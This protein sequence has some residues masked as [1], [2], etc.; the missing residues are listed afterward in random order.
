MTITGLPVEEVNVFSYLYYALVKEKKWEDLLDP[1]KRPGL[2]RQMIE[3]SVRSLKIQ[4]DVICKRAREILSNIERAYKYTGYEV[5]VFEARLE[6][7]GLFGASQPFGITLF[8]VGL[9][10]DPYLNAPIIPGSSVKGA[11]RSAWRALFGESEKESENYVFGSPKRIGACIF[12]NGYPIEAGKNGYLLYPDVITPH[13][14]KEGRD[15]L[16]EH[17][18]KPSPIVYLTVAPGTVF[19]FIIAMPRDINEKL[20]GMLKR[21]IFEALKL[22]IGGKTSI[23]FGR[24]SL[25]SLR[26]EVSR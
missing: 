16:E 14:M 19:K 8:E 17:R 18:A 5:I 12:H 22:G 3:E 24:F 6:E 21:A 15:I 26:M 7:R 13:Y 10:F 23:G 9:E 4:A 20:R 25:K 2:K 11:I 1:S